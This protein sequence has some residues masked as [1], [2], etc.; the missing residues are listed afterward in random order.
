ME[1]IDHSESTL[2]ITPIRPQFCPVGTDKD[3]LSENSASQLRAAPKRLS[4]LEIVPL[5][6]VSQSGP[7]NSTRSRKGYSRE[8]TSPL[9]MA[10][11][12]EQHLRKNEKDKERLARAA[13]RADRVKSKKTKESNKENIPNSPL[14]KVC[15][16]KST[17]TREMSNKQNKIVTRPRLRA[18]LDTQQGN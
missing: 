10:L 12:E 3:S 18:R 16:T 15:S 13:A 14:P 5:P 1:E 2:Q 8:A 4:F 6:Q 9:E 17:N 7:R 11:L